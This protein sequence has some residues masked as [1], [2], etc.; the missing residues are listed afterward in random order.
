M[1]PRVIKLPVFK[2]MFM[3]V[4]RK[5][6]RCNL[7]KQRVEVGKRYVHYIDRR[8]H[9]IINYRFHHECFAIVTEYC[10]DRKRPN[11]TPRT[12]NNWVRKKYCEPCGKEG[13]S[14]RDCA[15][16]HAATKNRKKK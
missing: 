6:W 3:P 12:V 14:I 4:A 8:P 15:L 9:E 7:C 16:I 5:A 13:C 1:K 2:T 10:R 11:F